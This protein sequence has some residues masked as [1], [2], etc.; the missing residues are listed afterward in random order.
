M[1]RGNIAKESVIK[2]IANEFGAD[3]I[4]EY[5]KK[6][7]VWANDGGERVQIAISLTCPKTPI[8][9]DMNVSAGGGD[10]DFSDDA[11]KNTTIAV[12]SAAPAEITE[13]EKSNLADLM[14]RLGL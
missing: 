4:G 8:Q 6:V 2:K 12:A 11:P 1:A 13:E 7:Y 10:W 14:S 5:D 9:V 3:F